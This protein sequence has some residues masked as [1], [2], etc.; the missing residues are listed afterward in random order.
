MACMYGRDLQSKF[1]KKYSAEKDL[2]GDI[3]FF[4]FVLKIIFM[5]ISLI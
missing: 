4:S 1:P 2:S 3:A 5:K